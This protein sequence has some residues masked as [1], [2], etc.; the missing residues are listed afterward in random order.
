MGIEN[1]QFVHPERISSQLYCSICTNVLENPVITPT[2]HMFCENELLEWFVLKG[3]QIC[4]IT[5]QKLDASKICKPSR[6]ISNMLNELERYCSNRHE[7]CTWTGPSE[8][9]RSHV[10]TC[11]FKPRAELTSVIAKQ[12]T[13]IKLLNSRIALSEGKVGELEKEN[14][15]LLREID[16][17][18]RKIRVYD[19]FVATSTQATASED[20]KLT[21]HRDIDCC[22]ED[23]DDDDDGGGVA[24]IASQ[25]SGRK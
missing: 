7:G 24:G 9:V 4:P 5:N 21:L 13:T 11:A 8:Q 22:E 15:A 2:D 18:R 23:D 3:D 10:S 25:F 1:D 12:E 20:L 6:I 14:K 19:A 17:L 16:V